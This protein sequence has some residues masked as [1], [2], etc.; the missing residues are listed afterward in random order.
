VNFC[1][2]CGC[3]LENISYDCVG[4]TII[5]KID[6]CPLD[7]YMREINLGHYTLVI[8]NKILNSKDKG[9]G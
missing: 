1:P 6:K 2:L 4:D 7:H 9:N 5:R 8:G 3:Q